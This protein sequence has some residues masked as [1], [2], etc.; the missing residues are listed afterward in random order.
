MIG[1]YAFN[2]RTVKPL[3][4]S[5]TALV[6]SEMH[7]ISFCWLTVRSLLKAL[8]MSCSKFPNIIDAFGM[9]SVMKLTKI[10]TNV[11]N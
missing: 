1:A 9:G 11:Y 5:P 8:I 2:G 3:Y 6:R 4:Q 10:E 7:S